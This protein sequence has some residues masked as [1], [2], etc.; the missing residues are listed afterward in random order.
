MFLKQ[1]IMLPRDMWSFIWTMIIQQSY[2]SLLFLI[3][4]IISWNPFTGFVEWLLYMIHW[5]TLVYQYVLCLTTLGFGYLNY[6]FCAVERHICSTRFEKICRALSPSYIQHFV[7]SAILGGIASYCCICL[8]Q[9]LDPD[10]KSLL[11]SFFYLESDFEYFFVV[12]HGFYTGIMFSLKYFICLLYLIKLSLNQ[13]SKSQQITN[14]MV[15]ILKDSFFCVLKSIH[16]YYL[17]FVLCGPLLE[18][19]FV[20]VGLKVTTSDSLLNLLYSLANLKLFV[21]TFISGVI[22][23]FNWSLFLIIFNAYE[24]ERYIFPIEMPVKSI[25]NKTLSAVLVNSGDD[26]LQYLAT[27]DLRLLSQHDAQRRKLMFA[28][29]HPGG[30]AH[31]WKAISDHSISSLRQFVNKLNEYSVIT[32]GKETKMISGLTTLKENGLLVKSFPPASPLEKIKSHLRQRPVVAYFLDELPGTKIQQLF[33]YSQPL[34]W[35]IEA[36]GYFVSA[37]YSE[38]KFGVIQQQLPE[39]ICLLL[40]IKIAEEKLPVDLVGIRT[41][42]KDPQ[43]RY[44]HIHQRVALK[45][46][47]NASLCRI[48]ETFKEDIK[49]IYLPE[50][51]QIYF[52]RYLNRSVF[53]K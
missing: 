7:G 24:A 29:S 10:E 46:S 16:W 44:E 4:N 41:Y 9:S 21:L 40:D 3:L 15:V 31:Q 12:Q 49:G 26:I 28:I 48:A 8:F 32:A 11:S 6:R 53:D 43:G 20:L 39:I 47:V 17:L 34:I 2:L 13:E 22:I 42:V 14:Q 36:L 18:N 50:L 25:Q 52:Q 30:H 45:T 38:D 23:F 19:I 5:K 1:Q 37:S 35:M 27:M 51:Y 33:S